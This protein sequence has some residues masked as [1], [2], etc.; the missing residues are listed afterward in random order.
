MGLVDLVFQEKSSF[1]FSLID[2]ERLHPIELV[3]FTNFVL[4]V[5][6]GSSGLLVKP[7]LLDVNAL[8]QFVGDHASGC[9]DWC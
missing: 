3:G 2:P 9:C 1:R 6:P 5:G 7:T 4:F 8:G